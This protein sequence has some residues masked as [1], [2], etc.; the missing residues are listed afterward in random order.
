MARSPTVSAASLIEAMLEVPPPVNRPIMVTPKGT[1]LCRPSDVALELLE[2]A[3]KR[4]AK[5]DGE[6]VGPPGSRIPKPI[7]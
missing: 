6:V 4:V 5:E 2:R 3:P 7:Y 1:R